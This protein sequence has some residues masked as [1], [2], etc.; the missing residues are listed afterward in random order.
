[1][2]M[3]NLFRS[4]N[5]AYIPGCYSSAKLK[6]KIDNYKKI[7]KKLNINFQILEDFNCCG[8]ILINAGYDK[9]ARKLARENLEF[10]QQ[11]NIKKIITSCPLCYKTLSQDYVEMLPDWNIDVEYILVSILN[12]LRQNPSFIKISVQEKVVYH[13]PCYLSRFSDIY[14]Q[15]REI[16]RLL[17]YDIAELHYNKKDSICSGSCGNLK[18]TNPELANKI[19][20]DLIKLIKK[21]HVQK[22]TTPDPQSFNHLKEN[23]EKEP[24]SIA[25]FSELICNA[26]NIKT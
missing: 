24:I 9:Q 12:K 5:T 15:P 17:G 8:G 11:N 22:I 3:F 1:M 23:L 2:G 26:L 25:E 19:A 13:D 4:S 16:L 6:S 10:F 21:T 7:L 20:K 18:Q 14:K